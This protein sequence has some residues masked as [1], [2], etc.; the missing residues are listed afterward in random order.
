MT[1][2][3]TQLFGLLSQ[4]SVSPSASSAPAPQDGVPAWLKQST[5][6]TSANRDSIT[7]YDLKGNPLQ[8]TF[9][10]EK[11]SGGEGTVYSLPGND[12]FL[13]K[14]YK[15]Q[16]VNAPGKQEE[17]RQKLAAMAAITACRNMDFLAWPRLPV[18]NEKKQI[19]G[20]VMRR[21]EGKSFLSLRGAENVTRN[22][23]GWDRKN[24]AL[25]AQDFLRKVKLL[26]QYGVQINDFNPA[27]FLVDQNGNVS[28]ID[29][30]SFQISPRGQNVSITRTFFPSHCPPELLKNKALLGQVRNIQ[31]DA[32][33]F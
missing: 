26:S 15:E 6:N 17:L 14:I 12:N 28:F 27:N 8:L 29:C 10:H 33:F 13:I 11:A 19:I 4:T 21:C 9:H 18:F 32:L 31:C 24:L 23:P 16:T 30:D 22:F 1:N 7:V 5:G 2:F 20:F 3:F 25:V